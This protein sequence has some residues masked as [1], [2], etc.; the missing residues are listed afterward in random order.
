[1]KSYIIIGLGLKLSYY[2]C[3][4]RKYIEVRLL[5]LLLDLSVET[6]GLVSV[7][8]LLPILSTIVALKGRGVIN[9]TMSRYA[10]RYCSE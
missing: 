1:M 2:D 3:N 10:A 4:F 9:K 5:F 7:R 6:D 8:L